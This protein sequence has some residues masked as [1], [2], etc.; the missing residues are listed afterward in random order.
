MGRKGRHGERGVGRCKGEKRKG[1]QE[2]KRKEL[3]GEKGNRRW[4]EKERETQKRE[5]K[6]N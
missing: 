3:K 4:D 1:G 6:V 2:V 5:R